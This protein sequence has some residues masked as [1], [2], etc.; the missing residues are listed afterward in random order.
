MSGEAKREHWRSRLGLIFATSGSA[1]GLGT[2]W[3]LPYLVGQNGGGAFIILFLAFTFL[4]GTP[5]FV[6]EL[7]LGKSSQRSVI[8]TFSYFKKKNRMVNF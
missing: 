4:L 7:T 2:L 5:L 3:K 1:I 8:N 6:A